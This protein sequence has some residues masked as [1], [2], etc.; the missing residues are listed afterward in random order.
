MAKSKEEMISGFSLELDGIAYCKEEAISLSES[1]DIERRV[2]M[3]KWSHKE[4]RKWCTY[5]FD[6]R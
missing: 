2:E 3:G 5:T 1:R 6:L 4:L